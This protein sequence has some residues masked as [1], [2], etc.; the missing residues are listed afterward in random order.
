MVPRNRIIRLGCWLLAGRPCPVG[1][2]LRDGDEVAGFR[3]VH[4]PGH[5]PGHVVYF[6]ESDRVA[7]AGDLLA[8]LNFL[9]GQPGLREPPW[10]FSADPAQNRRSVQ[11]LASLR[12]SVVCFGHGPPLHDLAQLERIAERLA[13]APL[14]IERGGTRI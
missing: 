14:R 9:T 8:N 3:V 11:L 12:P 10:F 5:T 2:V 13:R 1:R 7:L 6:R 4:T